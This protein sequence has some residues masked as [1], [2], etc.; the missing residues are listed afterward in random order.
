[1]ELLDGAEVKNYPGSLI[2]SSIAFAAW[3]CSLMAVFGMV[4]K[5]IAENP[6]PIAAIGRRKLRAIKGGILLSEKVFVK[7]AGGSCK[8]G[9]M[10]CDA[11]ICWR[12]G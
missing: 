7:W 3:H 2:L 6:I 5:F 11:P 12:N 8:F 9:N 10:N 4:A 1:M